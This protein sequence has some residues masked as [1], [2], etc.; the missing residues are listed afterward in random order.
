M[1]RNCGAW[2]IAKPAS[3]NLRASF[4]VERWPLASSDLHLDTGA[5]FVSIRTKIDRWFLAAHGHEGQS[6]AQGL[7]GTFA[8]GRHQ[9]LERFFTKPAFIM[10]EKSAGGDFVATH[11]GA[12][13][14]CFLLGN[15]NASL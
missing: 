6:S 12:I 8:I 2:P 4:A 10:A 14:L 9:L 7:Q 1:L 11:K 5:S 3:H 15:D 13:Q